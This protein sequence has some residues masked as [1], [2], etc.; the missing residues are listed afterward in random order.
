M[1]SRIK[2]TFGNFNF[3]LYY[4]KNDIR[5]SHNFFI[6]TFKNVSSFQICKNYV[7]TTYYLEGVFKI[8]TPPNFSLKYEFLQKNCQDFTLNCQ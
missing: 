3:K 8:T 2:T 6:Q 5:Y 7:Y 1:R 4:L